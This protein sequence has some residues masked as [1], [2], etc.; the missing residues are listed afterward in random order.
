MKQKEWMRV[1]LGKAAPALGIPVLVAIGIGAHAGAVAGA[2]ARLPAHFG[3]LLSDYTP[4]LING[5]PLK[6]AP[7]EMH[8]NWTLDLNRARTQAAFSAEI[9]METS[10]VVNPDPNFDPGQLSP[11]TH[12]IS[13]TDGVVHDGPTDWQTMCPAVSSVTG[14]F[15]VTGSAYVTVNGANAPFG[16]P[17]P[18]TICILGA[19]GT[20]E[21]SNVTLTIGSPANGHFG[22][23]PIHGVVSGCTGSLGTSRQDCE[24]AVM[25]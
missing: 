2:P 3:G 21:F 10:E 13:V 15:A 9:A 25:P 18:V 23:Q 8:G 16:N 19:S 1:K 4:L 22:S 20:V 14:G 6:G 12:H 7:Y 11:H 17:S 24:V 5:S